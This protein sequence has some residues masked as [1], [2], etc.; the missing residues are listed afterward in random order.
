MLSTVV[1]TNVCRG[2]GRW[3]GEGNRVVEAAGVVRTAQHV[4]PSDH[5][6]YELQSD[7]ANVQAG[8]LE[9]VAAGGRGGMGLW[10]GSVLDM[11]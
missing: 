8:L 1:A 6:V 9:G 4:W 2:V 10:V 11:C 5:S 7:V 3:S